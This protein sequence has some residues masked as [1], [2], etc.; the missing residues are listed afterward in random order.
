MDMETIL[1]LVEQMRPDTDRLLLTAWYAELQSR[2]IFELYEG[3][4]QKYFQMEEYVPFPNLYWTYLLA[5]TDMVAGKLESY[6]ASYWL[7][8]KAW[9]TYREMLFKY[10]CINTK[11]LFG[12]QDNEE[13]EEV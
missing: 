6:R 5:M 10:G 8:E 3:D 9:D 13:N 11:E 2:I 7:F 1:V 12:I 4:V